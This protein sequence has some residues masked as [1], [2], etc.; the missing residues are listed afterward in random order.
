MTTCSQVS[1]RRLKSSVWSDNA[2]LRMTGSRTQITRTSA[3][4][5]AKTVQ[6]S[7]RTQSTSRSVNRDIYS[8]L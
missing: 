7:V 3:L 5:I 8:R 2:I 1:D 6:L 4:F